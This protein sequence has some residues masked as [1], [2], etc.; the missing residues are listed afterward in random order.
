MN[1]KRWSD[2]YGAETDKCQGSMYTWGLS[3]LKTYVHGWWRD[4]NDVP[5]MASVLVDRKSQAAATRQMVGEDAK[6]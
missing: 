2:A 4:G 1:P 5:R 3:K 6:D